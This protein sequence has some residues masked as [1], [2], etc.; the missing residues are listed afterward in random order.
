MIGKTRAESHVHR[1]RPMDS[2]IDSPHRRRTGSVV[3]FDH[4]V[5]LFTSKAYA[6]EAQHIPVL[7]AKLREVLEAEGATP[8]SHDYKEIVAAF[9]SFPKDELFRAPVAELRAQIRLILDVKSEA[10]GA[11]LIC[12]RS[13]A[14]QRDRA[15]A[16][17]ARG[18]LGRGRLRIQE[19]LAARVSTARWSTIISRSAKATPRA[20]TSA[21]V[22]SRRRPR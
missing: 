10:V 14:R 6:E 19:A 9:N 16:D 2:V 18:V 3:A 1:R 8:G 4:F 11:P 15:G 22:A 17:A 21:F 7:R 12:A 20:C 13:A 5:G